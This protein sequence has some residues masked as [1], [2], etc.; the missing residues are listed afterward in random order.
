MGRI[1]Y[2]F[3]DEETANGANDYISNIGG[4]P[5]PSVN[6]Y[7]GE[8]DEDA[9]QTVQWGTPWPRATDG[10]WVLPYV[11]DDT[12]AQYPDSVTDY[13]ET[14]FPNTKEEIEDSWLPEEDEESS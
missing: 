7:T 12:V 5:V 3:D 1:Y 10:K 2:V 9:A 14:N 13:F 8:V 4:A 6:A 11:G